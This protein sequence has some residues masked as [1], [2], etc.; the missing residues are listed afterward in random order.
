M[1]HAVWMP[2]AGECWTRRG[3]PCP[4]KH[5]LAL[6]LLYHEIMPKGTTDAVYGKPAGTVVSVCT[7]GT[8]SVSLELEYARL[9]Y[10]RRA[11]VNNTSFAGIYLVRI[12]FFFSSLLLSLSLSLTSHVP[13]FGGEGGVGGDEPGEWED[14]EG[15]WENGS[16]VQ[17]YKEKSFSPP[18]ISPTVGNA[19]QED[20]NG[21]GSPRLGPPQCGS[22]RHQ[23]CRGIISAR[24]PLFKVQPFQVVVGVHLVSCQCPCGYLGQGGSEEGTSALSR[25]PS[26]QLRS[27][28]SCRCPL[29]TTGDLGG[30]VALDWVLMR[31]VEEIWSRAAQSSLR[32][33]TQRIRQTTP[34]GL[35]GP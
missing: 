23:S 17:L 24:G 7:R 25:R 21:K 19:K 8:N 28:V 5:V 32:V 3:L 20:E 9:E 31:G 1:W 26:T 10:Q 35:P 30:G 12:R 13:C 2:H 14:G 16:A 15:A 11:T 4:E 34:S 22:K 33:T 29:R 18:M 6:A 27:C